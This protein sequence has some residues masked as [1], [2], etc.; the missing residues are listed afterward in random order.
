MN[1]RALV[2]VAALIGSASPSMASSDQV[3][4]YM[5][6]T[7]LTDNCREFLKFRRLGS[8]QSAHA[9]FDAALCYGFVVGILD[10]TS[11]DAGT[12][13]V[14]ATGIPRVFCTGESVNANDATEVVARFLDEHPQDRR[15]GGYFLVIRALSEAYPCP[16]Q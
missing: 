8:I 9:A 10:K 14:T 13:I 12:S 15:L 16:R 11:V 1:K 2:G 4:I 5:S 3:G 6:G 7:H